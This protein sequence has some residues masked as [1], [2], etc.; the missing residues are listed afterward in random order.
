MKQ[1]III[2]TISLSAFAARSQNSNLAEFLSGAWISEPLD[3]IGVYDITEFIFIDSLGYFYRTAWYADNYI[4]DRK[5]KVANG[6]ILK[7]DALIYQFELWIPI[8]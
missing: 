2:L 5:L 3:T 7:A 8:Q 1:L 4:L 6:S